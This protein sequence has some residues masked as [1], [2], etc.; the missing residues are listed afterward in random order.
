MNAAMRPGLSLNDILQVEDDEAV[1]AVTCPHTDIPLWALLRVPLLR[2][3]LSD[4]LYSV[5]LVGQAAAT[6]RI[7]AASSLARAVLHDALR[8]GA[9]RAEVLVMATGVGQQLQEGRWF[10]RLSDHFAN[11]LPR[12]TLVIE[13]F[14]GW[15]WPFP[16]HNSRV[17][18]S[19]PGQAAAAIFGKLACDATDHARAARLVGLVADRA[20]R[21]LGWELPIAQADFLRGWL[22]RK[23]AAVPWLYRR[24][25]A[26][27]ERTGARVL[28]KEEA[29][30]GGTSAVLMRAARDLGIATAEYQHG[31]ISGGHDA[32]NVAPALQHSDAYR[33]TLPE[34]LLAYGSWWVDQIGMPVQ[35]VAI[36]N[37]HRA[38]RLA[39]SGIRNEPSGEVLILGDG[40]ET[41][42]YMALAERLAARVA[43][44]LRVVFR[45]HPLEREAVR[46]KYGSGNSAVGIDPHVDIYDA[47]RASHAVVSELSTGLFE[48][49]GLV[50]HVFIW[51]TPKSRF[52]FP[53]HPF[54]AFQ[55]AD[56]LA[57]QL[58][59]NTASACSVADVDAIWQPDWR[60]HYLQFLSRVG[61]VDVNLSNT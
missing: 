24:H 59:H 49:V 60:T 1:L 20:R 36:G 52:T 32:Y 2:S 22:A 48:A 56:D 15:R 23:A 40:L 29:C 57:M 30:Y 61:S 21:T 41:P 18:F 38:A 46:A 17:R 45:P 33:R 42:M 14:F 47:L 31:A 55:D 12:Q 7:R 9:S 35:G 34:H 44:R 28:I 51:D 39:G 5:P 53:S 10:N 50:D 19:A 6:P 27:L 3:I 13:D 37:P 54:T 58:E 8:A 4:A 11:A 25:R 26:M 43:G 16:R